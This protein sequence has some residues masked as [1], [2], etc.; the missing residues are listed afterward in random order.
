MCR[1]TMELL[2]H[3]RGWFPESK[4]HDSSENTRSLYRIYRIKQVYFQLTWTLSRV[5]GWKTMFLWHGWFS[6][7]MLVGV[8]CLANSTLVTCW[9]TW[10]FGRHSNSLWRKQKMRIH[11]CWFLGIFLHCLSFTVCTPWTPAPTTPW[12][13]IASRTGGKM[14]KLKLRWKTYQTNNIG[15][16]P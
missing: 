15:V 1:N 12:C 7:S 6:G 13:N 14:R 4:S 2:G 9:G 3:K 8:V 5:G 11:W 16:Y 10:E